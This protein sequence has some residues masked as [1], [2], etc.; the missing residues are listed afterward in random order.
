MSRFE[1]TMSKIFLF[2]SLYKS[3]LYDVQHTIP[4]QDLKCCNPLQVSCMNSLIS[5]LMTHV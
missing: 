4:Q 3:L 5:V 1:E 2:V